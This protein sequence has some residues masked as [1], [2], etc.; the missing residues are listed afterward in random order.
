MRVKVANIEELKPGQSKALN[1]N[2][3]AIALFNVKGTF[4]AV[5]DVCSHMGAPLANGMLAG[6]TITCEWHGATFDLETG[7]AVE[8]P[9]RGD[10]TAYQVYVQGDDVELEID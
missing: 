4:Y 3:K 8:G 10:I 1:L 5:E 6:K 2:G 9:A 7:A